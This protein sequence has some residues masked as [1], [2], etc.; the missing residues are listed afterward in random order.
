MIKLLKD[1]AGYS[2]VEVMVSMLILAVAII[3]MVGM[4]DVGLKSA[5]ASGKYDQARALAN[6][7][8]EEAKSFS[9]ARTRDTFPEPLTTPPITTSYN[10][11]G[12]Y[13]SSYKTVGGTLGAD[14]PGFDY[15]VEKQ[16]LAPPPL[17]PSAPSQPFN[18]SASDAG[19]LKVTVTVRWE[20]SKT[21]STSGVVSN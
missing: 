7:K 20:G 1:E 8:L 6:L 17:T 3:P 2:L 15:R 12:F 11:S 19:L 4:F 18:N 13:Q 21:Y 16:F 10:G 9:Y 5:T 14:F